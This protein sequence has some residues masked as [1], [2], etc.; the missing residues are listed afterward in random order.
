MKKKYDT[1]LKGPINDTQAIRVWRRPRRHATHAR[2]DK[3]MVIK[4]LTTA[5]TGQLLYKSVTIEYIK[6]GGHSRLLTYI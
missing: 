4:Q 1:D 3:K 6:S 2:K 5:C